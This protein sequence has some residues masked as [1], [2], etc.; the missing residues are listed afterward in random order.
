MPR[1]SP[2]RRSPAK[3]SPAKPKRSPAKRSPAKPKRSPAKSHDAKRHAYRQRLADFHQ[4]GGSLASDAVGAGIQDASFARISAV[5][6]PMQAGGAGADM[7]PEFGN[8][9]TMPTMVRSSHF[10]VPGSKP[11]QLRAYGGAKKQKH[12]PKKH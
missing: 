5:L 3:R 2:A 9:D 6:P 12:S 10:P 4:H 8:V 11:G 7:L 1:R